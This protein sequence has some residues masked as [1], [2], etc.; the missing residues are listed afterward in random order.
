MQGFSLVEVLIATGIGLGVTALACSLAVHAQQAWRADSSRSDLQQRVRVVTDILSQALLDAGA[1]PPYGP[2]R[3]S[4]VRIMAPVLPRRTGLRGADAPDTFRDDGFTVVRVVREAEPATLLL[5]VPA[6]ASALELSPG[7][8]EPSCGFSRG[9]TVMLADLAG[10]HD[11]FTVLAVAGPALTVR[12]HGEGSSVTYPAGSPALRVHTSS[13]YLD[14]PRATLR[15]YDGDATDMPLLDDV[16]RVGVEYYGETRPPAWPRAAAGEAN[17]LYEV[18]GAYRAALM[19]VLPGA[20]S[21]ARLSPDSLSDG[22][23]CGTGASAFDADLLRVRRVRVLVRLQASDPAVRGPDRARFL[24]PGTARA[25]V[26]M[27]PDVSM[28]VDVALRNF[29]EGW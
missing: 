13:I 9:D 4:L 11:V 24:R 26:S 6:G 28:A 14:A 25:A 29:Q 27:V 3:G 20:S 22:P 5:G 16:V 19:P 1:G 8:S 7:C 10:N 23:W 17:C 18:D 21:R 12:H 2:A 15:S